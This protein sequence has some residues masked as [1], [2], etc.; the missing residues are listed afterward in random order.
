[1]YHQIWYEKLWIKRRKKKKNFSMDEWCVIYFQVFT[2]IS[3]VC[4]GALVHS[5]LPIAWTKFKSEA[6][7]KEFEIKTP[8]LLAQTHLMLGDVSIYWITGCKPNSLHLSSCWLNYYKGV[9]LSY[10]ILLNRW[11]KFQPDFFK[12]NCSIA[13]HLLDGFAFK[14]RERERVMRT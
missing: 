5:G 3:H 14:E 11:R 13:R 1:V 10:C 9:S 4:S 12:K 6:F 7:G 8:L 2:L